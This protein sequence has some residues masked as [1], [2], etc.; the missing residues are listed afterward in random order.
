MLYI[1]LKFLVFHKRF[2]K[3]TELLLNFL[4]LH[5]GFHKNTGFF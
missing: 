2:P 4:L 3:N 5:K 1:W